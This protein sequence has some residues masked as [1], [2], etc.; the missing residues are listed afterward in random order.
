MDLTFTPEQEAW[1][2]EVRHFLKENPRE[3]FKVTGPDEGYG[4]GPSSDDFGELLGKK[5][6]ISMNWPKKYGGQERPLIDVLILLEEMAYARAPWFGVVF[7]FTSGNMLINIGSEEMKKEFLPGV[8]SGKDRFWLAMSEPDAGSDLTGLR[9]KAEEKD[10]H[11]LINGQKTWSSLAEQARLGLVYAKTS[12]DPNISGAKS[13]SLFVIDG[14]L[15]GV[16]V[17]P[18][19]TLY[20]DNTHNEVFFEDVKVPKNMILGQKNKG[21]IHMLEGLD[22]DRFWGRFVKPPFLKRIMEDLVEY[23][24]QTK[25]DGRILAKDPIFRQKLAESA[26]EIEACR[27][28]Y[29]NAA[30]KMCTGQPYSMISTMGK[31]LADEMG[32]RFFQTAMEIMG[33]SAVMG[34]NNKWAPL[35]A[36]IQKWYLY[37]FGHTLAGGGSEIIR[38]T[39]ATVGLGMPRG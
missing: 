12:F 25:R 24:K 10:D 29:W 19:Y 28:I 21:F 26:I 35:R 39:I 7:N 36:D 15:P 30:W 11:Y 37:S 22:F 17:R 16:T 1:R 14:K 18:L 5:G 33:P 8:A 6:W 9:T 2:E 4:C 31:L 32:Q 38:N 23:M 27:M 34:E 13:I 3:N 20:G